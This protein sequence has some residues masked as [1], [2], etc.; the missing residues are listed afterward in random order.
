MIVLNW[1]RKAQKCHNLKLLSL[2]EEVQRIMDYYDMVFVQ[3]VYKEIT[4]K[5]ILYTFLSCQE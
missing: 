4:K 2:L 3:H 1:E 5:H